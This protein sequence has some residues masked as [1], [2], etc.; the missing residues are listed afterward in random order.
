VATELV[1]PMLGIQIENGKIVEW[2][3]AEG[4]AVEKG[5]SVFL[6]ETEKVETE[7]ESPVAGTLAKILCPAGAEV[8]VLTV[9]GVI[10][11]PGEQLPEKYTKAQPVPAVAKETTA[12]ATPVQPAP[13]TPGGLAASSEQPSAP[14]GGPLRAMPA[15]RQLAKDEGFDLNTLAG[16]GPKGE[17]LLKDVREALA[18][19]GTPAVKASTLAARLARK[20]GLPLTDVQGS[21]LRGRIMR[22][23][24][25]EVVAEAAT[26]RLGKAIAFDS[27]RQVIAR[28]MA[29]SAFTAPHIYFFA[30]VCL[31]TLLAFRQSLVEDFERC[32]GLKPSF[33]DFLIKAVARN[34]VDFPILNATLK[35]QEIHIPSEVNIGLAVALPGG[36]VVPAVAGADTAGLVEI[37][38]QRAD[39]V[40]RA[41]IGKLSME[42]LQRGTFT[43]SSL[44]QYD[45]NSFTA[46][47]NPPQSGILSVGKTRDELALVDGQVVVKKVATFGLSVDHRV[48]DGA[49]AAEFLQ[50]LKWKLERPAF[51]FLA[52]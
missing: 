10:T 50:N 15:A 23:D 18:A 29:E 45:I 32:Y 33:N 21:G 17:I 37:C 9:V 24:V 25:E 20:E 26:P 51:T 2:L 31:D 8:P 38:R 43:I 49:V 7:V 27:M 42:E 12:T 46:I 22:T 52:Q 39:L 34:I 13:T 6:V 48:I 1:L 41:R 19:G 44:A 14:A 4:E 3:K 5:E 36:L 11:A 30:D 16:T 47:I 40:A 35:G 28:R